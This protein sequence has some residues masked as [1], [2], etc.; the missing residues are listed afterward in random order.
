MSATVDCQ[1][2]ANYFNRCP[3]VTIPGRTFPVEVFHLEDIVEETGYVLEQD[4]E[5]T[6][7]FVEEEEEVS[8]NITQK[9]GKTLQHQ[10]PIVRDSGPGWDLSPELDHFSS[11]TRHVL[12][13]MNPNK[14]NMD[15]ILDLLEYLDKSPQFRDVDGAVL[16]FLP[17]LAH[18]QQLHDL[19]TTDKR[20]SS[21]DR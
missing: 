8:I 15:L 1:K 14:I 11:R 5:Y 12:Q 13:Y 9:G 16:I 2:F 6:Q 7:R 21:K 3:V 10:E 17:G 19:L 18:I 20:F 4:S